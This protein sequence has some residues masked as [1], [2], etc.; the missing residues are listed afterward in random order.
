MIFVHALQSSIQKTLAYFDL[1]DFPLT[2]EELFA[3]LWQPPEVNYEK[4]LLFL[5]SDAGISMPIEYKDGFYFLPGRASL[6]D[7]RRERLLYSE[8]KLKIARRAARL[9]RHVPFLK[10]VF[11]CNTVG[12]QQANEQSDIDFLIITAA[13]RIWITRLLV[14]FVLQVFGLRRTKRKINN[15]I[16]LSFYLAEDNLNLAHVRVADDDIHF[17]FWIHQMLPVFDPY[18]MYTAFLQANAWV[19]SYLPYSNPVALE[20]YG[21]SVSESVLSNIWKKAWEAMWAGRYGDLINQEA[22]K[23]QISKMKFSGSAID[24]GSNTG[25]VISDSMLKFHEQD[26]RAEYRQEWLQKIHI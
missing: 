4:F 18:H 23:I 10:G 14:T 22:K 16:C 15:K 17:A 6:I 21:M 1:A 3:Y 26:T 12:A 9:I 25:V 5:S 20:R 7:K 24:R 19:L 13:Q 11:V 8:Y 2:R